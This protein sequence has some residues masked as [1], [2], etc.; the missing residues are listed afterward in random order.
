MR[1]GEKICT[2]VSQALSLFQATLFIEVGSTEQWKEIIISACRILHVKDC[3]ELDVVIIAQDP[4]SEWRV[5][6]VAH[7][8]K[9]SPLTF[10]DHGIIFD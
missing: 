9:Q 4:R 7:L 1:L 2:N 10:S 8:G 5:F 3:L 6:A